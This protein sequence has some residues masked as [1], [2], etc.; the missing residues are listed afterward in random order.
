M[1]LFGLV[2]GIL[3]WSTLD[4]G[5]VTVMSL[6]VV[7]FCVSCMTRY[8]ML[9]GVGDSSFYLFFCHPDGVCR[10]CYGGLSL[11]QSMLLVGHDLVKFE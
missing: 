5:E 2:L 7:N 1:R 4:R 9:L 6:R 11:I 3:G 8:G 10:L